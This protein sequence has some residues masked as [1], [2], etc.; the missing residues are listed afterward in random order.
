[1]E[2][3]ADAPF[4]PKRRL[5][6]SSSTVIL[7]MIILMF[8]SIM[9]ISESSADSI[10]GDPGWTPDY[11]KCDEIRR[12]IQKAQ[13][14]YC[15]RNPEH[16]T[17]LWEAM[18]AAMRTG[19]EAMPTEVKEVILSCALEPESCNKELLKKALSVPSAY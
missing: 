13:S 6:I 4:P 3:L 14:D 7:A 8:L 1:M 5:D 2:A 16:C 17:T 18:R 10:C 15:V 11:E 9:T 19:W 12:A